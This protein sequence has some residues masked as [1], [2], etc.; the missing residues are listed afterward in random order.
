MSRVQSPFKAVIC[1]TVVNIFALVFFAVLRVDYS[2]LDMFN[3]NN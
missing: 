3:L 2:K 1:H